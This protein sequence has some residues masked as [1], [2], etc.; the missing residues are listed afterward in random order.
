MISSLGF[1]L[2]QNNKTNVNL[3]LNVTYPFVYSMLNLLKRSILK[4]NK[5]LTIL[6][7]NF[8]KNSK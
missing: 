7:Q 5:L 8:Q 1:Y 4:K 2:L 6:Q 3:Q